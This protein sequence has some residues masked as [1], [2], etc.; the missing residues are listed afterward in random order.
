MVKPHEK[1]PTEMATLN[2]PHRE[3]LTMTGTCEAYAGG[4]RDAP[5][6]NFEESN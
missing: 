2:E 6:N 4:V 5:K 3:R 1:R